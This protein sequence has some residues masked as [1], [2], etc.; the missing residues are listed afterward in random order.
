MRRAFLLTLS[1]VLSLAVLASGQSSTG[2]IQGTVKDSQGAVIPDAS[3][4]ITNTGTNLSVSL[5]TGGDGLFT[6]PSLEPGPYKVEA[7]QTNFR[8][9]TE[10]VTLETAQVVNLD[11]HYSTSSTVTRWLTAK[12]MPRI[13]GRS[14][15]TTTSLI[16]FSPSE[17]SE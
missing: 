5:K 7:R 2:T 16:R 1:L 11:R 4:T 6:A 10:N 17:R 13:S 14:S 3:V 12:I 9:V 8:T 15:L